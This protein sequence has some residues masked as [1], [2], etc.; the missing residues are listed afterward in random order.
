MNRFEGSVPLSSTK[1]EE[2][3]WIKVKGERL[4]VRG[5]RRVLSYED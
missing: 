4:K 5:N 2:D 1:Q 3:E